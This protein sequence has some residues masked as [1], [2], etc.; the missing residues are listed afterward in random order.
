MY[1]HRNEDIVN[2]GPEIQRQKEPISK[3]KSDA[4]KNSEKANSSKS[5]KRS[6]YC[7]LAKFTHMEEMEFSKWLLSATPAEREKVLCDYKRRKEKIPD[8]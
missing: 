8:G 6:Q 3:M 5:K 1:A 7:L 4:K 2:F